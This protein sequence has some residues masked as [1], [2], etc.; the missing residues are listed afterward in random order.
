MATPTS[1]RLRCLEDVSDGAGGECRLDL[2]RI[3]RRRQD[4]RFESRHALARF[5]HHAEAVRSRF[6][7]QH[8]RSKLLDEGNRV[9]GIRRAS[10]NR[11]AVT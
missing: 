10:H 3:A 1:S 5:P 2:C 6:G 9:D 11:D 7:H 4:D 8:V